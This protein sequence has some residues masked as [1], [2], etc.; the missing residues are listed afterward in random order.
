MNRE[1]EVNDIRIQVELG[2]IIRE[3]GKTLDT[4]RDTKSKLPK[5]SE[6]LLLL[7]AHEK[8][9][10]F[11]ILRLKNCLMNSDYSDISNL[12]ELINCT[13]NLAKVINKSL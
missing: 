3:F 4:V 7:E 8:M 9:M 10:E 12:Y 13:N 5:D 11:S 1:L 2:I 6:L